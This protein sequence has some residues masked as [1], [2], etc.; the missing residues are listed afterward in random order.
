MILVDTSVWIDHLHSTVHE[1]VDLLERDEVGTH[2]AVVEEIALGSIA[3]RDTVISSLRNL[4][5]FPAL[6]H[7]ELLELVE[8]RRLWG[9]GL[10][11]ADAHLLGSVLVTPGAGLW[12]RDRRLAAVAAGHGVGVITT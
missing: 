7:G 11:P 5:S 2:P 1:L 4:R 12:T 3:A 9:R 10:S 6:S 8:S